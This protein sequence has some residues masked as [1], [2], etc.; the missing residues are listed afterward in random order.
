MNIICLNFLVIKLTQ[1]VQANLSIK[2][3]TSCLQFTC[4]LCQ[5]LKKRVSAHVF[6]MHNYAYTKRACKTK[7]ISTDLIYMIMFVIENM[8]KLSKHWCKISRNNYCSNRNLISQSNLN[9][10]WTLFQKIMQA[11]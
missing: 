4:Q 6:L 5:T 7:I 10:I 11:F 1:F 2:F 3:V 8:S 9:V